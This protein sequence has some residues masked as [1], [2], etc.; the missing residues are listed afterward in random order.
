RGK[1]QALILRRVVARGH[2][3]PANRLAVANRV[4]D[5]WRGGVAV[6]EQR[7]E[8]AGGEHFSGRKGKFPAQKARVVA[9]NHDGLAVEDFGFRILDFRIE[10]VRDALGGESDISEG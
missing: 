2:V 9:H 5:N 7:D 10:K 3:D 4:S 8:A 1:F 6:A